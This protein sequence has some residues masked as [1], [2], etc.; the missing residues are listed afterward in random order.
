M[1]AF[2]FVAAC[3]TQ[4]KPTRTESESDVL[5]RSQLVGSWKWS[6]EGVSDPI[7][8]YTYNIEADGEF[9]MSIFLMRDGDY[10]LPLDPMVHKGHWHLSRLDE[11]HDIITIKFQAPEK[12]DLRYEVSVD[13]NTMIWKPLSRDSPKDWPIDETRL[14]KRLKQE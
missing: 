10:V 5:R 12:N 14:L 11:A 2:L 6:R 13:G 8:G 4:P 3:K 7:M 1:I 9:T